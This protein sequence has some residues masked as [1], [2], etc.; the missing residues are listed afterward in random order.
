[1]TGLGE[2]RRSIERNPAHGLGLGEV[3]GL[4]PHF[5]DSRVRLAPVVGHEVGELRE[6]V[7]RVAVDP[8]AASHVSEGGV[9][10]LAERVELKLVGGRVADTDRP[11]AAVVS[12]RASTCARGGKTGG[13]LQVAITPRRARCPAAISNRPLTPPSRISGAPASQ[14]PNATPSAPWLATGIS[15]RRSRRARRP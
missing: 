15:P 12:S 1:M 8:G 7:H 5:P 11:R 2:L 13:S 3:L 9:E 14:L 4:H 10:Q 6:L